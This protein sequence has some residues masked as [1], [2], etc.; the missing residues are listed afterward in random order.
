MLGRHFPRM[1]DKELVARLADSG[2]KPEWAEVLRDLD[3]LKEI[4]A[5]HDRMRFV[6]RTSARN[7][8]NTWPRIAASLW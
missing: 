4:D 5:D 6:L 8:Q 7:E 3:R 2:Y 1:R